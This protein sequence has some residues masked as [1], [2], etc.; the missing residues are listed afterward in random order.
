MVSLHEPRAV[1]A[2]RAAPS[3][4]LAGHAPPAGLLA[5]GEVSMRTASIGEGIMLL[6][7]GLDHR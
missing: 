7:A 6:G 5:Q 4:H 3:Q 1:Y 2:S